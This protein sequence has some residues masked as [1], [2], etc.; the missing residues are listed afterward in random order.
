MVTQTSPIVLDEV[1]PLPY[2]LQL[3]FSFTTAKTEGSQL[4]IEPLKEP[5][6]KALDLHKDHP[7]SPKEVVRQA[8]AFKQRFPFVHLSPIMETRLGHPLVNLE[9]TSH[10]LNASPARLAAWKPTVLISARQH[11]NEPTS[12]PAN[13]LWLAESLSALLKT[14]N[15]IFNPLE[16][17]D[18]ARLYTALCQHA[19][20]HMHHAARYTSLG[21]DVQVTHTAVKS[22]TRYLHEAIEERWSPLVHLNN[23][24]YPAHEW[25]RPHSGYVPKHFEDWSLPF[26]YLTILIAAADTNSLMRGVQQ[27]VATT[28]DRHSALAAFTTAQVKRG[29]RYQTSTKPPFEFIAS[30]PFLCRLSEDDG[31]ALNQTNNK[32][33]TVISEVPDETVRGELWQSCMRAHQLINRAVL[34]RVAR[35]LIELDI[36]FPQFPH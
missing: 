18:G 9:A 3:E 4:S 7:L 15:I 12:T 14:Y 17:P 30:L 22:A 26:G 6:V 19:P 32:V 10:Y 28:L 11:A 8:R 5:K 27:G 33:L 34:E 20:H 16:N 23:H 36:D 35:D 1:T 24:G 25:T 13:F 29:N 2:G 21:S 31:T